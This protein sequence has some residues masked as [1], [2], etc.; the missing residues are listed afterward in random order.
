[1]DKLREDVLNALPLGSKYRKN[2]GWVQTKC[3]NCDGNSKK[4]HLNILLLDDHPI[5][6]RC[7][8]A[9]CNTG[10]I[11]N[12][13]MGRKLGFPGE[14]NERLEKESIRFYKY[15]TSP[16]YYAK[17]KDYELGDLEGFATEYFG[18]R[19][20]KDLNQLQDQL[21]ICS[22]LNL[23]CK[24]NDIDPK[25]AYPVTKWERE[26]RQF[27]YFFNESFTSLLY[28]EVYGDNA[29]GRI[30]LIK[31]DPKNNIK[32]KPYVLVNN[33]EVKLDEDHDVLILSEGPF[34]IINSLLYLAPR[35]KATFIAVAGLANLKTIIME[36]SKYHY[37]P[38]VYIMSDKDV[39]ISWYQK[40]LLKRIDKRIS[41]LVVFYNTLAKDIGDIRDGF[42]INRIDVKLFNYIIEENMKREDD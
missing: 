15:T 36:F 3:P 17:T 5:R 28:R 20:G 16:K 42:N 37:R 9:S 41:E 2:T 31:N 4:S 13:L 27:I 38:R 40:Y 11:V 23:F 25:V 14:L 6:Y 12:R 21:R 10:G 19:T 22:N 24:L 33:G 1:M 32:H 34:D 35:L 30:S 7:F 29:K 8:R 26:G 18:L 39:D